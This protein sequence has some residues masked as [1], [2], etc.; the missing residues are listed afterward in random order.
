MFKKL[1]KN[2]FTSENDRI[3]NDMKKTV[4]SINM[5]EPICSKLSDKDIKK[6]LI[7][8]RK[9]IN[10]GVSINTLLPEVFAIVKEANKRVFN[11]HLFDSQL[12]G[13][14][15]LNNRYIAEMQTGEGKTITATLPAYLNAISQKGVHIIT[16]NDYLSKR[17]AEN[18]RPL[19]EFLGLTVGVNLSNSSI[20]EKRLAY[21]SDI[22]YG[23]NNEYAFDYLR[24][25][26]SFNIKHQVQRKLHYAII[27]EIDSILIDESRTPLIISGSIENNTKI[28]NQINELIFNFFKMD[29][30]NVSYF[31]IDEKYRK[32]LLTEE[33]L[34]LAENLLVSKKFINKNESLYS[35][36]NIIFM[37]YIISAIKAHTLFIRNKDYIIR[38]DEIV[39]IDEHTGRATPGRRW[40]DGLH[41]A[42][43]AKENLTVRNEN[44]ILASIT[45]QNYFRL[46]EKLSGMTGTAYTESL[47]FNEIYNLKTIVIPTNKPMIRQDLPDLIFMT[48]KEKIYAIVQDIKSRFKI[49]QPVLVGTISIEK[50][51]I[52]SNELKKINIPHKI[53]NAK[54]HQLEA[55][56]I[57][58]A[59]QLKS[60]TISTNMA[61]RGTDIVLGGNLQDKILR[62]KN[63]DINQIKINWKTNHTK[64]LS[65]GGLHVIGTERHESRRIDNQLRGRSGRQGDIGSS[66]FYLSME[67]SLMRIFLSKSIKNIMYTFGLKLNESIEHPLITKA[68]ASA[69]KKVE[70]HNFNTRKQLLEYDNVLNYQRIIIYNKRNEFLISK[71]LVNIIKEFRNYTFQK[72]ISKYIPIDE[73]EEKWNVVK[74]ENKFLNEYGLKVPLSK[75]INESS[76]E[77]LFDLSIK[78][79]INQYETNEKIFGSNLMRY[80]EKKILINTIDCLWQEH[81]YAIEYMRKGIHLRSYAQVDPKQEYQRESFILFSKM[82][83]TFKYEVIKKI[84]KIN[85]FLANL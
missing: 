26:M 84:S 49:G 6:K 39:I 74:L 71:N 41:Q 37:E 78:L 81:L 23:T 45:F 73:I 18:N 44:Y 33:G 27:D 32:V 13:G 8:F 59:G 36:K 85:I 54:F 30:K 76:E 40:S 29:K 5:L 34:I 22:T 1:F 58:Q 53:L 80:H 46:Y 52:I 35:D 38:N 11:I 10:L 82:L 9:R 16:V 7:E 17:D 47:E 43:E 19:F 67:D 62:S 65:L 66:R 48:E 75:W 25:N 56:I 77:I 61:G 55:D 83:K 12:L 64:V 2:F 3:L 69:Q 21:N 4:N 31:Y 60:I 79:S 42:I 70:N 72:L 14:I 24:D 20:E 15:A 68:I 63:S 50:S 28:F 57:A 51:E